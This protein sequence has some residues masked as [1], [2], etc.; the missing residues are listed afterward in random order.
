MNV[1]QE[2]HGSTAEFLQLLEAATEAS[3][4]IS[5]GSGTPPPPLEAQTA[6]TLLRVVG[7]VVEVCAAPGDRVRLQ[8]ILPGL[9]RV[10]Q[11]QLVRHCYLGISYPSTI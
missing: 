10:N 7:A 5:V 9:A 11:W 2:C 4:C 8:N 1:L 3:G 6:A